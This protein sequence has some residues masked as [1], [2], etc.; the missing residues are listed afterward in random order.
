MKPTSVCY[1]VIGQNK[2]HVQPAAVAIDLHAED[3]SVIGETH[4]EPL[5]NESEADQ[6]AIRYAAKYGIPEPA[7]IFDP[8]STEAFKDC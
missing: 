1:W 3:G 8:D 7:V 6:V 5:S 2:T 4:T